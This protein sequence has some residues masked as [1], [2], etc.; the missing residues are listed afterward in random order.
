[1]F[2]GQT[3]RRLV[4]VVLV[5]VG[6][7]VG[8]ALFLVLPAI[9]QIETSLNLLPCALAVLCGVAKSGSA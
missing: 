8:G 9:G 1:M 3:S 7:T 6:T 5:L 2:I 4:R